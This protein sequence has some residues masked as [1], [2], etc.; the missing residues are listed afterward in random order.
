MKIRP[1]I[2]PPLDKNFVPAVLW[3]KAYHSGCLSQKNRR[4]CIL[5][6]RRSDHTG[7]RKTLDLWPDTD[8]LFK[9]NLY[10]LERTIKFLLWQKGAV[11][12]DVWGAD[13]ETK[14][15]SE[16][17]SPTGER[18]FDHDFFGRKV[19]DER[20]SINVS[21][22]KPLN[23][24][25]DNTQKIGGHW[26]GCRIGFDLGGSDRKVAA[27]MDGK[28]V[29]E[30]ETP[31][32][33]Y[34][35]SDIAYHFNGIQDSLKRAAA[36]LPHVDAIGG[37]AAGIYINNEARLASIF[38]GIAEDQY[39]NLVRP[40]FH[41]LK[42]YWENVPF[43]VVNDG[44]VSALAGSLTGLKGSVLGIAMGTSMAAGYVN[45]SS[46]IT[47][48]LNELAFAPV[49]YRDDASK[50]EWSG[51]VG[52]G[53][54]YFSQQAVSRL[55]PVSSIKLSDLLSQAEQLVE[56]QDLMMKGDERACKIF[57]TI[58][59]Y[60]GYSLACFEEFYDL[61]QVLLMGRV[62]TGQ[63][64]VVIMEK[65]REVLQTEFP[66]LEDKINIGLPDE[67]FRRLGQAV[68]AA[69]LP[70]RKIKSSKK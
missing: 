51:D 46:H 35:Q 49:D 48:W 10:Y 20:F 4:T 1:Q 22:N 14:A 15:L 61:D 57:E 17:Y 56:V 30:D 8:T 34:Y 13:R 32:N 3:R 66:E 55:I 36:N 27:L 60:L 59:I 9:L 70:E 40:L 68:I 7:F 2:I 58:G 38:R 53:V 43:I 41:R 54:Q 50:D 44:E 25:R 18:G 21:K 24:I 45:S 47:S 6:G 62:T 42:N 28:V 5:T 37:S 29:F 52:C 39:P 65:A 23:L 26:K 16:I 31:W 19:Y 33:P 11:R 63:G 64:G 12:I 67:R 69:S